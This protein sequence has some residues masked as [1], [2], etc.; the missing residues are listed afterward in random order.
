MSVIDS[1][2]ALCSA[3]AS[4]LRE[5]NIDVLVAD[6]VAVVTPM[7]RN[8]VHQLEL[9]SQLLQKYGL[10]SRW[11]GIQTL[12]SNSATTQVY[13]QLKDGD[14]ARLL[15]RDTTTGSYTIFSMLNQSERVVPQQEILSGVANKDALLIEGS[16]R[17]VFGSSYTIAQGTT[18]AHD[19]DKHRHLTAP[20]LLHKLWELIRHEKRDIV[21]VVIY[22]VIMGLLS[23]VVPLASQS[24]INA[25]SLGVYSSQLGLLC[26]GVGLGLLLLGVFH[27]LELS[28][29]DALRRRIF[30]RTAFEVS[31]RLPRITMR[32]L[33]GEYAPE[34]VNRFFDV[35]TI[36]KSLSKF[37]L[38]G[39][40]AI[41][42][43]LMGLVLLGVYHPLFLLFDIFLISFIVVLVFL[44]GRG[45]LRTS[46]EESRKKY[47][48]AHW[49]EEIARCLPAFKLN[50]SP[51]FS[52]ERLNNIAE[53]Y[54]HA[55]RAHFLVIARQVAGSAFFR[56]VATVGVLGLGGMLVINRQLTL[57]Q[58]VA[59]ELVV[60]ALLGSIDKL[61]TQFEDFYD[62]LTGIDKLSSITDREMERLDSDRTSIQS[63]AL[64]VGVHHC[65]FSYTHGQP[66]LRDVSLHIPAASRIS[67]IGENGSG[68][69][70]FAELLA[71]LHQADHG[72]FEING[73]DIRQLSL[74]SLRSSISIFSRANYLFN[75]TLEENI[76]LGRN[77]SFDQFLWAVSMAGLKEEIRLLPDGLQFR[78]VSEGTN[79]PHSLVRRIVLARCIIGV[80]GLIILDEG[81]DG[82]ER[83]LKN[84]IVDRLYADQRWSILDISHDEELLR[85]ADLVYTLEEGKIVAV[86]EVSKMCADT[87]SMFYR[88]FPDLRSQ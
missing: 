37:L 17:S 6:L 5:H 43:A 57:G 62:L 20:E 47:E 12:N 69:T 36:T 88:L 77:F 52:Y 74:H 58:L 35:T 3:A 78:I 63:G 34:L 83:R 2:Y 50:A 79:L 32:A 80:P 10:I 82:I 31:F 55:H 11:T 15:R 71:G 41:L 4:I 26:L 40:S 76:T 23:L 51:H 46:I 54:V 14:I 59:A 30:I 73:I 39:V 49:L 22:S 87:Q 48:V 19:E 16:I 85:R 66:V 56:S 7:K 29:V 27:V 72:S 13:V 81:L 61:I 28:V 42:V 86:G 60:I 84:E 70:T 67:L 24:L 64:E 44:L 8:D 18:S 53:Q 9:V 1:P 68:K 25:V 45:G 65:S 33:D 38:D 21:V 75:G